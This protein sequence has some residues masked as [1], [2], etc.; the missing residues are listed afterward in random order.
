MA[1]LRTISAAAET[2]GVHRSTVVRHIEKLEEEFG[3]KLFLRDIKGYTPNEFGREL[4]SAAE[5]TDSRFNELYRL[6]NRETGELT[7]ELV[8]SI[9]DPMVNDLMP[10]LDRFSMDNPGVI[11]NLKTGEAP[12]KLE[13]GEADI[14]FRVGPKPEDPDYVVV[15]FVTY[16][17]GLY[18]SRRYIDRMGRPN[19]TADFEFHEFLMPSEPHQLESPALQ[20]LIK[21]VPEQSVRGRFNVV[22]NMAQFMN[23]GL[24]IGFMP[25]RFALHLDGV[26]EIMPT[27]E[28]WDI[29][30]WQVTHV[31]LHKTP[32]IRAFLDALEK[33]GPVDVVPPKLYEPILD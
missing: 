24:G 3:V 21:N 27:N 13:Y 15:P 19:S 31:D 32:K 4:L 16:T 7:G 18:A 28:I 6:A 17:L 11:L 30:S 9:L 25:H 23:A 1:Q 5:A 8:I 12:S 2:L 26:E 29:P 10:A 14:S 20:W 33:T 22:R